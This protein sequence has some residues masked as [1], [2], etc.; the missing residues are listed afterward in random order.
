MDYQL[1]GCYRDGNRNRRYWR[2]R[3]EW[4]RSSP[5]PAP[6]VADSKRNSEPT[7][8]PLTA[9]AVSRL[10]SPLRLQRLRRHINRDEA[11]EPNVPSR[12]AGRGSKCSEASLFPKITNMRGAVTREK[13]KRIRRG[14]NNAKAKTDYPESGQLPSAMHRT[15]RTK[16]KRASVS[17]GNDILQRQSWQH[18]ALVASG[19]YWSRRRTQSIG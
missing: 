5:P 18:A 8:E 1:R 15:P 11:V 12:V 9:L 7:V 16:T 6:P 13:T 10:R 2:R 3:R 17:P 14:L 4:R 19:T